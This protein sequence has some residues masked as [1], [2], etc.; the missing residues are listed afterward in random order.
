MLFFY[1]SLVTAESDRIKAARIYEKYCGVMTYVAEITLGEKKDAAS[2]MVHEAM[3]KIIEKLDTYDFSDEKKTKSLCLTIVR[4]KC[5]DFLEKKDE[6]TLSFDDL[7][8]DGEGDGSAEEIVMSEETVSAVR[9]AVESLGDRYK[10]VCVLK[11][12][13]GYKDGEIAE[14]LGVP[15]GTVKSRINYA[16]KKLVQLIKEGR[17]NE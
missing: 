4:N 16:R 11:F 9:R 7:G 6:N 10:D 3:I 8:D 15:V 5:L 14:I 2:D 1:M 13:N 12:V 17:F